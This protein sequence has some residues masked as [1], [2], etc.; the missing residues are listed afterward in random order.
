MQTSAQ[1][2]WNNTQNDKI[3]KSQR[4]QQVRHEAEWAKKWTPRLRL[5]IDKL[6]IDYINFVWYYF[7]K[8]AVIVFIK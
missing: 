3:I 4:K 5:L 1:E 2:I 7:Y 6:Q 8:C